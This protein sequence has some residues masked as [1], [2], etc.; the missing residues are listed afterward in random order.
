MKTKFNRMMSSV[1][2]FITSR[3]F[4]VEALF[5]LFCKVYQKDNRKFEVP[6]N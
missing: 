6:G 4:E 5:K 1:Y 2:L 3:I